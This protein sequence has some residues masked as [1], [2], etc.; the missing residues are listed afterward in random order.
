MKMKA[1]FWIL[2]FYVGLGA[3]YAQDADNQVLDGIDSIAT[4][5]TNEKEQLFLSICESPPSFKGGMEAFQKYLS[6]NLCY[7][8]TATKLGTVYVNFTVEKDGTITNVHI[9]RGI[10]PVLDNEVLRVIS[11]MPLWIPAIKSG[12]PIAMRFTI[13]IKFKEK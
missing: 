7:P 5:Q 11:Q 8:K 9:I 6:Q 3:I 2:I 4:N 13:P 10:E 12:K 1:I